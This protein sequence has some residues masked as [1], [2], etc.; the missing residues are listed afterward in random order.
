M[1]NRGKRLLSLAL[2]FMFL[3]ALMPGGA[4]AASDIDSGTCGDD[5]TWT[6]DSDGV[7]RIEG[8]G[9]MTECPWA[10]Y[11]RYG[12]TSVIIGD[13]V[14]SIVDYAF[15]DCSS[16]ASVSIPDSVT[17]IGESAFSNC[18][19]LTGV[20]IPDGV[21]KICDNVFSYCSSLTSVSIPD[22][23]TSIGYFAF[24]NCSSL[25][26][27]SIPDGVTEI[28][29]DAFLDCSSLTSV[30]IPGSVTKIGS[31]VFSG[32]SSLT[33]ITVDQ[34]NPSYKDDD[35]VL[36]NKNGTLL[37]QFHC[38]RGGDYT[39]PASVT[40]IG[41]YAF[42]KCGS[43][44]G[45]SVPASVTEIGEYAFSKCGSLTGV[46][47]PDSV[48][49]IGR[50]AFSNCSNLTD[51][52]IPD[53][54]SEIGSFAFYYCSSL[55]GVSIPDSV[56]EI[57]NCAFYGCSS[58]TGITVDQANP[59][60][61][62]VD[63]VL[64]DKSGTY[65]IQF[66][67]SRGGAYIIPDGVTEIGENAFSYCSG[68]TRVTIPD[69]MTAVGSY[70]FDHCS[71]LTTVAI[72][73]S[74]TKIGSRAFAW[75]NSLT[76]VYYTGSEEA[77]A[78]ISVGDGNDGLRNA[79]VHC[80][81]VPLAVTKQPEDHIGAAGTKAVFTVQAVGEEL[82]YQ[83]YIKSP[84]AMKFSKSSVTKATYSVTLSAAN[85]G[86]Q[87]YCVVSDACGRTVQ[88]NTVTMAVAEAPV[89]ADLADYTGPL[90]STATF[91]VQ[92]EGEGL[93]YQWYVKK[94]TATKFSK[95][96]ITG[97]VYSVAL[98]AAR[99]GNQIYCVVSDAY[100]N[101]VRTN[102]VTMTVAEAITVADLADYTGPLGSTATFT[103]QA[104][105]EGLSYQWYVKKPTAT[106]FSKSSITGPVYSVAL[107]AARNGNQ[108]YC[109]V[110]DAAGNVAR[111]N[112]VSMTV[113]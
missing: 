110:T 66:P 58:L 61:K 67:W 51:V 96:S 30:S 59:S 102:T 107:T 22:G 20:S 93:T 23:V 82:S 98:T 103:V 76:D 80:N 13:G 11:Y 31:S 15:Y 40:E 39:V 4:G 84:T 9:E 78:A 86:R 53:S 72:P 83:W 68:L 36:F 75:C 45:V 57:G 62:D 109:V 89:V 79:A 46:S 50:D 3:L 54:V 56:S 108:V 105:G 25:M 81:A 92:A 100:G 26:S 27:M 71:G 6:L 41:E 106:K 74:V 35:G 16:L 94:P 70:A 101:T 104:E 87:L 73:D 55:T 28:C 99:N 29:N 42:S 5:L 47:I 38:G 88:T 43:L 14:T 69:S 21:T 34:A 19:S 85:S 65:L 77:W 64:F 1:K 111:T 37:I 52:S 60:Y 2:A 12:I 10:D 33:S 112:T 48:T 63:G 49:K 91:T 97:P 90:G 17:Y 24:H 113:G 18:G 32:C 44:T 8:T 95:S 7:L